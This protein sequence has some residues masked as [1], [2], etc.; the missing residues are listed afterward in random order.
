MNKNNGKRSKYHQWMNILAFGL[1][2][3]TMYIGRY[4]FNHALPQIARE[5]HLSEGIMSLLDSSVFLSYA[6]GCL[7]N[8]YFIDRYGAKKFIIIGCA[9][10]VCANLIMSMA[11]NWQTL[12]GISCLN[13]FVQSMVWIGGVSVIAHWFRRDSRGLPIG[14]VNMFSGFAYLI[15]LY[16]PRLTIYLPLDNW[17]NNLVYP[18]FIICYFAVVFY[19]LFKERP[20]EASLPEYTENDPEMIAR[21]SALET[22]PHGYGHALNFFLRRKLLICWV[23]IAFLSSFCRYGMLAWIPVFYADASHGLF[24]GEQATNITLSTG[25][26]VGTLVA[27]WLAGKH[28]YQNK[29]VVVAI[30]AALCGTLVV[31]FPNLGENL[32]V[33]GAI[34]FTGFLLFGINGVLWLYAMDEGGR[35]FTGTVTGILNGAAYVGAALQPYIFSFLNSVV[36]DW[37]FVFLLVEGVCVLMVIFGL[38]VCRRDTNIEKV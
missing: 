1:L 10:T 12:L 19:A 22:V 20:S 38:L 18:L 35:R 23:V 32:M 8:G 16:A 17:R 13:G 9:G 26:A 7:V 29:G 14:V 37:M 6:A 36:S 21:E 11:G 34:F 27:A 4:N 25:M 3:S 15:M 28:F 33:V 24:M 2:Y 30:A 31:L 5:F